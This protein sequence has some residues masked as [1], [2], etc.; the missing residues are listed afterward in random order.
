[1]FVQQQLS[2]YKVLKRRHEEIIAL[3]VINRKTMNWLSHS[4][5]FQEIIAQFRVGPTS[6]FNQRGEYLTGLVGKAPRTSTKI[7]SIANFGNT[8]LQNVLVD[9]F[10][11]TNTFNH[12][13]E[14]GETSGVRA[15]VP[16]IM[17]IVGNVGKTNNFHDSPQ[18]NHGKCW[19]CQH[20]QQFP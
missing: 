16:G 2:C 12:S 18:T 7:C 15:I 11:E 3:Y 13:H 20:F 14:S 9:N 1:M 19:F 5:V 4:S 17:E 6:E 10:G 8:V